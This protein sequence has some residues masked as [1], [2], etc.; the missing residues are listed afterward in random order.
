MSNLIKN[1]LIDNNEEDIKDCF[2]NVRHDLSIND[3]QWAKEMYLECESIEDFAIKIQKM[4]IQEMQNCMDTGKEWY[5]MK[6]TRE[7]MEY[8]NSDPYIF[9]GI[10]VGNK[11]IAKAIPCNLTEFLKSK[12]D[13]EKQYNACHCEYA[14]E[15][16]KN[17]ER[18][19]PL[20]C[21]CS[22]GHTM[23]LWEAV[24][25]KMLKGK[26]IKSALIG[27]NECVFE[28]ELPQ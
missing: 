2:V 1:L 19:S 11:I 20:L 14:K 3:F 21:Y 15:S 16:I 23:V 25:S 24:F 5:G 8:V 7:I 6:I 10:P 27:D 9:Y 28:I 18:V 26:V 13:N 17:G 12:T 22:L 4:Q